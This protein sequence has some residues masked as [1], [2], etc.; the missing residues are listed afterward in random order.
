MYGIFFLSRML[1]TWGFQDKGIFCKLEHS[2]LPRNSTTHVKLKKIA[3]V[4]PYKWMLVQLV[5]VVQHSA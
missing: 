3:T 4:L 5:I 1:Q 2:P